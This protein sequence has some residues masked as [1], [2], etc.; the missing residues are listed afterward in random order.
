MEI[1]EIISH[2]VDKTQN[3]INVEFRCL[4]DGDDEIREDVI[5]YNFF[6]EFGYDDSKNFEIFELI[7]EEV[8]EWDN[9]NFDYV[10]NEQDLISFLNE[11]YVVYQKKIP[12]TQIK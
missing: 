3:I 7:S 12:K 10:T 4:G 11:Y 5:E 8:D 1:I 2:H 9:D 6:E